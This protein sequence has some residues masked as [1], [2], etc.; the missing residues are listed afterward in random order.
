MSAVWVTR[1]ARS[2]GLVLN[3]LAPTLR[4]QAAAKKVKSAG[5][6]G[7]PAGGDGEQ[8]PPGAR[9]QFQTTEHPAF[10]GTAGHAG[11]ISGPCSTAQRR[12]IS[13]GAGF[14]THIRPLALVGGMGDAWCSL[15][16]PLAHAHRRGGGGRTD[17][18]GEAHPGGELSQGRQRWAKL[19]APPLS[20]PKLTPSPRTLTLL[21]RRLGRV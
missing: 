12:A 19:E 9:I 7:A 8:P 4:Q 11:L 1:W 2:G 18:G 5:G 3:N 20:H 14:L 17:R 13:F 6:K 16:L 15:R 21:P 10:G